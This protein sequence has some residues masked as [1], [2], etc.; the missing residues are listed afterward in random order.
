MTTFVNL[1]PHAIRIRMEDTN[2]A[3]E[4]A[5]DLVLPPSGTVARREAKTVAR[6]YI[7]GVAD[8]ATEFGPVIGLPA[9]KAGV[10]YIVSALVLSGTRR[11]DVRGPKTD[12]TAI[13]VNGQVFAVR[14]L[15]R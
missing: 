11:S 1:T 5:S 13:R 2:D 10:I 4:L 15:Q 12:G 14:G 6:G 3:I 9:R 7:D 8:F